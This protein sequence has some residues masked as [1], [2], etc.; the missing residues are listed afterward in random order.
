MGRIVKDFN[1]ENPHSVEWQ[2]HEKEWEES[3][4][5]ELIEKGYTPQWSENDDD[6]RPGK[7]DNFYGDCDHPST[8]ENS[9]ATVL[10]IVAMI[11]SLLFKGGWVLC[12]LETVAWWKFITRHNK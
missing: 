10:W 8:M 4:R 6:T 3:W 7:D 1:P 12:I 5:Q 11:A 9:T 2:K